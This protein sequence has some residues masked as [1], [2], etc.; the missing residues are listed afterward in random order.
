MYSDEELKEQ[1]ISILSFLEKKYNYDQIEVFLQSLKQL[2]GGTE[3]K[4]QKTIQSSTKVGCAIRFFKDKKLYFSSFSLPRSFDDLESVFKKNVFPIRSK[5][6]HFPE[7]SG[8]QKEIKNIYDKK[9]SQKEYNT[10]L[11]LS[12]QIREIGEENKNLILDSSILLAEE[13]KIIANTTHTL[14]FERG[15]WLNLDFRALYRTYDMIISGEKHYS[16]RILPKSIDSIVDSL[17]SEVIQRSKKSQKLHNLL[18]PVIFSP[19]SFSNLLSF[20]LIPNI[21]SNANY[22]HAD[23]SKGFSSDFNLIDDG[24]VPGLPNSTAF[25]DEGIPQSKTIVFQNGELKNKLNNIE[26]SDENGIKTGNSFRIKKFEIF[27]RNYR[28]YPRV[29]PSNLIIEE[30]NKKFGN[31]VSEF[32]EAIY[33]N[34]IQGYMTANYISGD[35]AISAIDSYLIENGSIKSTLPSFN[36]KGNLFDILH[37]DCTFTKDRKVIRPYNTPYSFVSPY[38]ITKNLEI[39]P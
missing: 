16:S 38:L 8:L 25:D 24:T 34:A 2:Q 30:G 22:V 27:P 26:E 28:V 29:Y 4:T 7:I 9:I 21:I 18:L 37:D 23:L 35:F 6:F 1:A 36:I 5:H 13:R 12:N 17:I 14:A 10:I 32:D 3:F 11:E 31:I 39:L 33:I 15:T 19:E 20:I